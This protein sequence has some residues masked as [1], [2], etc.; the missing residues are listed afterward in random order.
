VNR[1]VRIS[2]RNLIEYV[3]RSGDIDNRFVS[4]SRAVEGTMAHQRVQKDYAK[5]DLKEAVLKHSIEYGQFTFQIEGRADGILFT[6][7]GIVI[8][9]IKSTTRDLKEL[10]GDI[11]LRHWAQ[12]ICYGY[13]YA[14][15]N[16]LQSIGIQLTYFNLETE[17]RVSFKRT[18]TFTEAEGFFLDLFG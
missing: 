1:F 13:I 2:V 9:E 7:D 6:D 18:M 3:L 4:M 15:Q 17:D 16:S 14:Y 10:A 5:G 11:N 8:D 12:G